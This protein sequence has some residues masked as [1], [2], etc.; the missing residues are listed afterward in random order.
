M[1]RGAGG[2]PARRAPTPAKSHSAT[3]AMRRRRAT[4]STDT[5]ECEIQQFHAAGPVTHDTTL[6][7]FVAQVVTGRSGARGAGGQ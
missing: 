6:L 3:T 2:R 4:H 7:F 1:V 5:R